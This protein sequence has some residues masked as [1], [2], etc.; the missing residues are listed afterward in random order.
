PRKTHQARDVLAVLP[1]GQIRVESH[2]QF[3]DRRHSPAGPH[4]TFG[5]T[6]RSGDDLEQ[7]A[8]A[9]T[10]LTHDAKRLARMHGE[11]DVPQHP[12]ILDVRRVH[13]EPAAEPAPLAPVIPE[14]LAHV[15]DLQHDRLHSTSTMSGAALRNNS[16]E[17]AS[18]TRAATVTPR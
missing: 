9:R 12:V 16:S 11:A 17:Q 6:Q 1:P 14:G 7:G 18:R 5:G 13:A 8:L 4:A 10:I 2:A 15:L 3:Q